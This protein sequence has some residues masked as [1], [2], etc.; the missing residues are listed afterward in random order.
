MDSSTSTSIE[1][2]LNKA[3]IWRQIQCFSGLYWISFSIGIAVGVTTVI[4]ESLVSGEDGI[5]M[6]ESQVV[7]FASMFSIVQYG[8]M[9][10]GGDISSRFGRKVGALVSCPLFTAGHLCYWLGQSSLTLF[11]GRAFHG[12][13]VG[14]QHTSVAS[15]FS[16]VTSPKIRTTVHII[17]GTVVT[18]G[19]MAPVL[20]VNIGLHWRTVCLISSILPLLGILH[21]LSIP[22]SPH[23]LVLR[24][25][26][27]QALKSLM[28][29]RGP[30]YDCTRER[31]YLEKTYLSSKDNKK[32]IKGL[33]V[34]CRDP[35]IWK[36]F[37][38]VL[39]MFILQIWTGM[40][41]MGWF[42]FNIIRATGTRLSPARCA[43][44]ERIATV[45]GQLLGAFASFKLS[46][47]LVF[48][49]STSCMS[50]AW[51]L[52][53]ATIQLSGAE[54]DLFSNSTSSSEDDQID[55]DSWT[56]GDYLP[57]ILFVLVRLSFQIGLAPY[58]WIYG[59][60]LFPLDLRS[61]LCSITSSLEPILQFTVVSLFPILVEELSLSGTFYLFGCVALAAAFF[62][63]FI[64]PE[65]RGKT[66]KEINDMFYKTSIIN[67]DII[68]NTGCC[69]RV[70]NQKESSSK[71]SEYQI[72]SQE[73]GDSQ[74]EHYCG[75][76]YL[77][78]H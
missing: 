61:Y 27:R 39:M 17:G 19:M 46:R 48:T 15:Y 20:M 29:L 73:E 28:K 57:P 4:C 21:I 67:K 58:P 11:I 43:L 3:N 33:L 32:T 26:M 45:V 37:I 55:F 60:E 44:A 52:Q 35:D 74:K 71:N 68:K 34:R 50:L 24:G 14:L 64:L 70:K 10:L 31:D 7:W 40:G 5:F 25:K 9:L 51:V 66:L 8:G 2:A 1:D 18:S 13:V 30:D 23:W 77:R 62:G 42:T 22:E 65:T 47:R 69:E 49:L 53:A 76:C 63:I 36:P 12:L 38:I 59:N 56:A 72:C 54:R 6:S 75:F 78:V 16:E 41:P